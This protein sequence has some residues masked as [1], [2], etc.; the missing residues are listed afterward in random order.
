[1]KVAEG[2]TLTMIILATPLLALN[3]GGVGALS[4]P[5]TSLSWTTCHCLTCLLVAL[6]SVARW[7]GQV[8]AMF[9]SHSRQPPA[10]SSHWG[11]RHKDSY[12][13]EGPR[14]KAFL[15]YGLLRGTSVG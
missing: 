11:E 10:S 9:S 12:G 1:M 14:M 7:L 8:D 2:I 15:E 5:F 4:S 13:F 6:M 3:D